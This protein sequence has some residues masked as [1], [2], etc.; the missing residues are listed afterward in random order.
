MKQLSWRNHIRQIVP[1]FIN[2]ILGQYVKDKCLPGLVQS[3]GR[4]V[5]I[6][7]LGSGCEVVVSCDSEFSKDH[8][9]GDSISLNG[10]VVRLLNV[11]RSVSC[12][13][14]RRNI[15]D[16]HGLFNCRRCY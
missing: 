5:A 2:G 6:T 14:F 10:V 11:K 1:K 4:V 16:Y 13:V 8:V 15:K 12:S 9:I 7:P 3:L